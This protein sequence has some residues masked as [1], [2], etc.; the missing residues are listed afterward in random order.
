[1]IDVATILN[2]RDLRIAKLVC[3]SFR[4]NYNGN[5]IK[6]SEIINA[7]AI[8]NIKITDASF[9]EILGVIREND[10][11]YPGFIV[12]DNTGYWYTENIEEMKRF[13]DSQHGR[14]C[15]IMKNI[16]ALYRRLKIPAN[17]IAIF[18]TTT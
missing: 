1:M 13:W 15:S 4:L 8:R 16:S 17:Q 7:L 11:C 6:S 9:R 2:D 18:D 12:S 10:M 3:N 5:K 14:V